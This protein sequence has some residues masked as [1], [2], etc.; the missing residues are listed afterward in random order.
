MEVNVS[1][2]YQLS[3]VSYTNGVELCTVG[4]GTPNLIRNRSQQISG[5]AS[6]TVRNIK[7]GVL[8][9]SNNNAFSNAWTRLRAH[10][11]WL[12]DIKFG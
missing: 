3:W 7:Y 9:I 1:F 10:G 5:G 11:R 4:C 8:C 6:S 12:D 2:S